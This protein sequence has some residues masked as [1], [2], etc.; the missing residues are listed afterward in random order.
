[1]QKL[2]RVSPKGQVVIPASLRRKLKISRTVMIK[3]EDE[4]IVLEP[5]MS[6]EEAFGTGGKEMRQVAIE[7]SEDRRNEVKSGRNKLS[8]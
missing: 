6:M 3:E 5:S 7:I 4:R 1:M 8:V 2:A